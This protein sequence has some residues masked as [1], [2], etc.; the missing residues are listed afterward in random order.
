MSKVHLL[1]EPFSSTMLSSQ[2]IGKNRYLPHPFSIMY[3]VSFVSTTKVHP[4]FRKTPKFCPF[5]APTLSFRDIGNN[6]YFRT[7]FN[8]VQCALGFCDENAYFSIIPDFQPFSSTML[9]SQGIG[10]NRYLPP[11]LFDNVLCVI[12]FYDQSTSPF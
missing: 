4:P 5:F 9:S 11:P 8:N 12:R 2:G 10:K 1:L 6:R 7:F 3:Y